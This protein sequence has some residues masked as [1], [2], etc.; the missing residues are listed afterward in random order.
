VGGGSEDP[1]EGAVETEIQRDRLRALRTLDVSRETLERLEIYVNLL[2]KW[3]RTIN[4]VSRS[5]L[6]RLWTRHI[7]DC[8][9]LA[10]LG[11]AHRVWADLGSG[12]GLPGIVIAI[13]SMPRAGS[14]EVHL[15]ERDRR[16]ASFLREAK[17]VTG[18]PVNIHAVRAEDILPDLA[19]RVSA[20]TAR[21]LAPLADLLELAEPLLTTCATGFFPKGQ[22]LESE[23]ERASQIFEFEAQSVQSRTDK[24][25]RIAIIRGLKRLAE[26]PTQ[27]K[28]NEP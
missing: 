6:P 9:Q 2:V 14:T 5:T 12:A 13:M 7:A 24:A 27:S 26:P 10:A 8:A 1:R 28:G 4:L 16:K 15:I 22:A 3:Q 21:A 18:A 19:G 23:L 11:S 20:V 17:R 25:G